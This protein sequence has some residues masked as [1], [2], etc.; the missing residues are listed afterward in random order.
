MSKILYVTPFSDPLMADGGSR[1]SLNL[2]LQI[3]KEFEPVLLTY[4]TKNALELQSWA[5]NQKI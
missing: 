2:L 4:R 1:R 5:S 3:Q